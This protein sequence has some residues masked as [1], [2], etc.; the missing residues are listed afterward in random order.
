MRIAAALA[1]LGFMWLG[2]YPAVYMLAGVG[3][4]DWLIERFTG[5]SIAD[6]IARSSVLPFARPEPPDKV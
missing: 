4:L 5:R 2:W 3:L 1:V 6:L